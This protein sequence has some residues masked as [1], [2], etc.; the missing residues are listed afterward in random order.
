[1]CAALLLVLFLLVYY[2]PTRWLRARQERFFDELARLARA[3]AAPEG[4]ERAPSAQGR[5]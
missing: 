4:I 3:N 1:M 2:R 5:G